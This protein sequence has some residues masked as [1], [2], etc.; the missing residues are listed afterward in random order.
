MSLSL[1]EIFFLLIVLFS[2]IV[3]AITGFAGTVLAMP[4]SIELVGYEVAR[5][6]LNAIVI[7]LSIVI[8]IQNFKYINWK[9]LLF[10]I[11]FVG[12]GFGIGFGFSRLPINQH[13]LLIIYGA[14][15]CVVAI[16]YMFF[17]LDKLNV[18]LYINIPLL[19]IAGIIHFLY[20]SGG[21][22]VVIFASHT[23]KDKKEFRGT[24]AV[25]WIILNLIVFIGNIVKNQFTG[26]IWWLAL[27]S[28]ISVG[29][30]A[31]VGHFVVKKLNHNVFMKITYSLLFIVGAITI[32]LN[33]ISL[34]K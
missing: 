12:I 11:L 22:L 31:V 28:L 25:M 18:P 9:A 23:F 2:N 29:I 21:P 15:I 8:M 14:L 19:I 27:L 17:H 32:I 34:A 10:M 20:T 13:I 6:I 30:A 33:S 16:A 1:V 26:H 3:Q 5:P 24:L 4:V 7:P